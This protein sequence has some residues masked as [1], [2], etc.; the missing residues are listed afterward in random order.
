MVDTRSVEQG[1]ETR[2]ARF[3]HAQDVV[4]GLGTAPHKSA[5]YAAMKDGRAE[6]AAV[7]VPYSSMALVPPRFPDYLYM[8]IYGDRCIQ[9]SVE[10]RVNKLCVVTTRVRC[11]NIYSR[12]VCVYPAHLCLYLEL[13]ECVCTCILPFFPLTSNKDFPKTPYRLFP[14]LYAFSPA[15]PRSFCSSLP[16][17]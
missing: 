7:W 1:G 10:Y 8:Y 4:F 12:C 11:C 15:N 9:L 3:L 6:E 16:F 13:I 17:L 5:G 2:R 14:R